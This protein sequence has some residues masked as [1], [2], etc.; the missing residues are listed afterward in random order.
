M[1]FNKR[2]RNSKQGF[3]RSGG[4]QEKE[5]KIENNIFSGIFYKSCKN[6][7]VVKSELKDLVPYFNGRI[8]LENREE[9]GKVDEIL[10][11]IHEYFYSVKLKEGITVHSFAPDTKFF[12]NSEQTL[13]MSRFMPETEKQGENQEKKKK[14]KKTN[15]DKK[16]MANSMN[17]MGGNNKSGNYTFRG[18]NINRRGNFS[19]RNSIS[20]RGN[21]NNNLHRNMNNN[22]TNTNNNN[23]TNSNNTNGNNHNTNTKRRMGDV[24]FNNRRGRF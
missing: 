10:G 1:S 16:R 19:N 22:G 5:L 12:I 21:M 13:P 3:N 4:Y 8:F 17:S 15:R 7:L 20:K 18:S 11:P 6:D 9:I 14:K 24:R 23:N 2:H